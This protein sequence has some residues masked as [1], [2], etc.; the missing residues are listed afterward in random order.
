MDRFD[1]GKLT[2]GWQPPKNDLGDG[3]EFSS[4]V[5]FELQVLRQLLTNWDKARTKQI[6]GTLVD[7]CDGGRRAFI[8]CRWCHLKTNDCYYYYYYDY[9][10]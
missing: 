1:L 9:I 6:E 4:F 5:Q 8:L 10:I 3:A 7:A 2:P